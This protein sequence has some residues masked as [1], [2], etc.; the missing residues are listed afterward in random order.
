MKTLGWHV[1]NLPFRRRYG[2]LDSANDTERFSL[3]GNL[4]NAA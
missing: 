2:I 4:S 1:P 3:D